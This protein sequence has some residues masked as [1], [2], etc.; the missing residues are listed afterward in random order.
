MGNLTLIKIQRF[1]KK[2]HNSS[3]MKVTKIYYVNL[4]KNMQMLEQLS[5]EIEL[6]QSLM[7]VEWE[8]EMQ[9]VPSTS[10]WSYKIMRSS[11]L[12]KKPLKFGK[13]LQIRS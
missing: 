12:R 4:L 1:F 7:L 13:L 11:L 3:S 8:E 5:Q 6:H 9:V 10:R 2:G